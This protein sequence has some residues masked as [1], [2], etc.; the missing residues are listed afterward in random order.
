VN[1]SQRNHYVILAEGINASITHHDR[2]KHEMEYSGNAIVSREIL[3]W[4]ITPCG[5]LVLAVL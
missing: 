4:P 2:I 1:I 3:V 5:N